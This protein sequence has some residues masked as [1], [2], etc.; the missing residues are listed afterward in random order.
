MV[1]LSAGLPAKYEMHP[2]YPLHRQHFD[3][4][5][6]ERRRSH[7]HTARQPGLLRSRLG[8]EPFFRLLDERRRW[9]GENCADLF[10]VDTLTER[11][12]E[13]GKVYR[14]TDIHDADWFRYMF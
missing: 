11:G 6:E 4:L 1:Y 12:K 8:D 10:W 9:I 14:F 5:V 13:T 7:P 3:A 2:P